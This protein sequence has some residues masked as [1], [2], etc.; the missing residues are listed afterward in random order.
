VGKSVI[1]VD[2]D[3]KKIGVMEKLIAH[4][5]GMLHRA[6]SVFVFRRKG[7]SLELLLQK[8]NKDKYHA[9]GLWTNTCCSHPQPKETT[10]DSAEKRLKKEMGIV[11]KLR[12]AGVFHYIAQFDNGLTENEIDHVFVGFYEKEKI[13][14]DAEEV[15][16]HRWMTMNALKKDLKANPS[17]YTPWFAK[18]LKVALVKVTKEK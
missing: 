14:P 3:D 12:E 13:R 1:L 9:G 8:R 6:F 4:R 10:K 18:A 5:Y 15:E 11:V 7:R 16:D 2:P 17:K